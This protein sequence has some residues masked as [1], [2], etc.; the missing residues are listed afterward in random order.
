M[1][2]W[3]I[4]VIH[5]S[6]TDIGYKDT[7]AKIITQQ[8]NNLVDIIDK[9][10]NDKIDKGW[11]WNIECF[12]TL[13]DFVRTHKDKKDLLVKS[14]RDKRIG[15][16]G[17]YWNFSK[18]ASKD[19]IDAAIERIN[20]F[21]KEN[22]LEVKSMITNDINGYA[23]VWAE[24]NN[25]AG[26][27]NLFFGLHTH[28]GFYPAFRK[29]YPFW[30][31]LPNGKKSLVWIGEQYAFGNN[32]GLV[33]GPMSDY[34]TKD[35]KTSPASEELEIKLANER[36]EE[37]IKM[38]DDHKYDF[39]I[40][41]ITVLGT[42][43]DNDPANYKIA[44]RVK[45]LEKEW[46]K[47]GVVE[48]SMV[49]LDEFFEEVRKQDLSKVPTFKG[50]WPD[51][52]T[53]GAGAMPQAMRAYREAQRN[54]SVLKR[55]GTKQDLTQIEDDL[56]LYSEHTYGTE[57]P[58]RYAHTQYNF[59][60]EKIKGMFAFRALNDTMNYIAEDAKWESHRDK[61]DDVITIKAINPFDAE[62][63]KVIKMDRFLG[64]MEKD[65]FLN[66][67]NPV[68]KVGGK[69]VPFSFEKIPHPVVD[70]WSEKEL[71]I[72]L[73][74]N[75]KEEKEI[76]VDTTGKAKSSAPITSSFAT[77]SAELSDD[78]ENN[79][80]PKVGI[81]YWNNVLSTK[82]YDITFDENGVK[83]IKSKELNKDIIDTSFE[84]LF[85]PVYLIDEVKDYDRNK[86][87]LQ[88]RYIGKNRLSPHS[89]KHLGKLTSK[90]IEIS[91]NGNDVKVVMKYEIK[92]S[93]FYE[94]IMHL[95]EHN[96]QI[97]ST[98]NL[99][100][101]AEW[102][103]ESMFISLPL[104]G[105][106]MLDYN[107]LYEVDKGQIDGS[108]IDYHS[109]QEGML[110][111]DVFVNQLDSA[112]VWT[113]NFEYSDRKLANQKDDLKR[114][115]YSWIF[116]NVWETNFPA[117]TGGFHSFRYIIEPKKSDVA[118]VSEKLLANASE[119]ILERK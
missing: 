26:I 73:E 100:K 42:G 24:Q 57:D 4:R 40:I 44:D 31:E 91:K 38:L 48:V 95:S 113:N 16:S 62:V 28:H 5:F 11:K 78:V 98:I 68:I 35:G 119:M 87:F 97:H 20:N 55:I 54:Y 104:E 66:Q 12:G 45:L 71:F 74:F 86:L 94:V 96:N 14:I 59:A 64:Y 41:P 89:V 10:S 90:E 106:R 77:L 80:S 1:K 118:D 117:D 75:P 34:I 65:R 60:T 23:Q 30:W 19:V 76:V 102:S 111:G 63:T 105:K 25:E 21:K 115:L 2:K 72:H 15:V 116:N 9:I 32:M 46:S 109:I 22:Q 99:N 43:A 3:K 84:P 101:S 49:T 36:I 107:N 110:I 61:N 58:I 70:A 88:R 53:D 56:L 81:K 67:E 114:G 8:T 47:Y 29:Q 112:L 108:L 69:V 27:E 50:E 37:Y 13:V 85:A 7:Q 17:N 103:M 92:N 51:W 18:L 33:P 82:F 6:H 93:T 79:N 52:W 39:D 83:Q